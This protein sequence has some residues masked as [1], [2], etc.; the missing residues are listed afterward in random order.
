MGVEIS[1]DVLD[2]SKHDV[3][4]GWK[5]LKFSLLINMKM[6]TIVHIY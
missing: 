2:Y 1:E 4:M 5:T 3:S 6:P